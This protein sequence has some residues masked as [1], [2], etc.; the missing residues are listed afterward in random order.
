M[1][2]PNESQL[3]QLKSMASLQ[4]EYIPLTIGQLLIVYQYALAGESEQYGERAEETKTLE[5]IGAYL[6]KSLEVYDS[7]ASDEQTQQTLQE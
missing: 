7:I 2:I 1:F 4:V 3:K 6:E 5:L